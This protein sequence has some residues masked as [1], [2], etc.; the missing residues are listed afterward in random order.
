MKFHIALKTFSAVVLIPF[1]ISE[2]VAHISTQNTVFTHVLISVAI[3]VI[4][5]FIAFHTELST[6]F[7][8]SHIRDQF[9]V[10]N[11]LNIS[12]TPQRILNHSVNSID[13]TSNAIVIYVL[14]FSNTFVNHLII[15]TPH[16][17]QNTFI[18]SNTWYVISW[19]PM[20]LFVHAIH[21]TVIP[22][23]IARIG[24]VI[25]HNPATITGIASPRSPRTVTSPAT[26]RDHRTIY[27]VSSGFL[28][29]QST[30]L[31][32]TGCI[33]VAIELRAGNRV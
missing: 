29:V 5:H 24:A 17:P 9:Q 3:V 33:A 18:S 26:A 22:A 8:P 1:H 32:I 19:I 4:I 11:H 2:K 21:S 30:M 20:K 23:I 7:I 13:N 31:A 16:T 14:I 25:I 28:L 15:S 27:F 6:V 10:N 12:N